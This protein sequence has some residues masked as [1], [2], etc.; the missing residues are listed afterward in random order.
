MTDLRT[1]RVDQKLNHAPH[2]VWRALT[3]PDLLASWWAAGDVRPVVGHRFTL[4][5]GAFGQQTCT[6]TVVEP[7]HVFAFTFG[8]GVLDSLLTWR[9][10]L[11]GTGSRLFLEH[12]GLDVDSPLGLQAFKGMGAGWPKVLERVGTAMP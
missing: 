8:E 10:E 3:E 5:M 4:D 9:I 11:E 12:S 6:V 7:E 2:D 1:I